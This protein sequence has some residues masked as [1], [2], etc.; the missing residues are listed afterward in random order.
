MPIEKVILY[1][2]SSRP[3]QEGVVKK[4]TLA[5]QNVGYIV[6]EAMDWRRFYNYI[7]SVADI[8]EISKVP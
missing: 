3:D 8:E 2:T 4:Y 1:S 5:G 6:K 7:E